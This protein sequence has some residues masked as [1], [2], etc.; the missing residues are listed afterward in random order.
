MRKR[1]LAREARARDAAAGAA[2]ACALAP[3]RILAFVKPRHGVRSLHLVPRAS[4]P[5]LPCFA[6]PVSLAFLACCPPPLL[7]YYSLPAALIRTITDSLSR[8]K[9]KSFAFFLSF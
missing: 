6:L 9:K 1:E 5:A 3:G 2:A 7:P 8:T 4:C